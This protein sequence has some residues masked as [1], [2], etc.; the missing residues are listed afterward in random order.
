MKNV[1]VILST[2]NEPIRYIRLAIDSILAQTYRDFELIAI[3]DDPDRK[4]VISMLRKISK[5]DSRVNV[6]INEQN[7]GLTESLNKGVDLARGKYIARMDADDISCPDRFQRQLDYLIENNYDLIGCDF[8]TIDSDGVK[9]NRV[10]T[11]PRT[12]KMIKKYLRYNNPLAH[13]S[14]FGRA[15]LFKN[16]KYIDFSACE[17]YEFLTRI[18]L[19]GKRIGNLG[20]ILLSY[21]KNDSGISSTKKAIQKTSLSYVRHNYKKGTISDYHEF[22]KY[23]NSS[24]GKRKT[25]SIEN[26]YDT[27]G[28]MKNNRKNKEFFAFIY[29]GI[30]LLFNSYAYESVY[31]SIRSR[32]LRK[33]ARKDK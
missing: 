10:I 28:K 24:K 15:E 20:G 9:S 17:D 18:A 27:V 1:S 30:A 26:Y 5:N 33:R 7:L 25:I 21:R 3:V 12:N 11:Y 16:N 2:Y 4:D 19:Q 29:N 23:L 13:P 8:V 14:W 22:I 32:Q 6:I 31:C